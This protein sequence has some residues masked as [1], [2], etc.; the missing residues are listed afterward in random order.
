MHAA[1]R[2]PRADWAT[3]PPQ[4][5][6]ER[7]GRPGVAAAMDETGQHAGCLTPARSTIGFVANQSPSAGD[8]HD[9]GIAEALAR[10]SAV[11]DAKAI[12][13]VMLAC[14]AKQASCSVAAETLRGCKARTAEIGARTAAVRSRHPPVRCCLL[15]RQLQQ[16]FVPWVAAARP[17]DGLPGSTVRAGWDP[18]P[19]RALT[20]TSGRSTF[21]TLGRGLR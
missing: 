11:S 4:S 16:A 5:R 7:R 18:S 17:C 3:R 19:H 2:P 1:R 6:D 13:N 9:R 10:R 14:R 21:A 12:V 8:R 15:P 20:P